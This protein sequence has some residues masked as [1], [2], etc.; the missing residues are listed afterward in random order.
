MIFM[1]RVPA[2]RP[3]LF[4]FCVTVRYHSDSGQSMRLV[5][6]VMRA[7]PSDISHDPT[8]YSSEGRDQQCSPERSGKHSVQEE[9]DQQSEE[10]T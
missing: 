9:S 2:M 10:C 5:F 6:V 8:G 4:Q 7:P 1:I 3:D